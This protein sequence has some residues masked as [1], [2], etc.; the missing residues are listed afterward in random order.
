[1]ASNPSES[2]A[3]RAPRDREQWLAFY[4]GADEAGRGQ[5]PRG[6]GVHRVALSGKHL[7]GMV[8]SGLS[9][10]TAESLRRRTHM[11]VKHFGQ[12][13]P[14][15]TLESKRQSNQKLSA[16]QSDRVMRVAEVYAHAADV[17]GDSERAEKWMK[18]TNPRMP[19][20]RTPEDMLRTSY[21]ARYVDDVL[22]Q[23]EHGIPA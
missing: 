4:L 19:E 16:E 17:F 2:A 21:G 14:R 23:I 12:F 18:R 8:E 6:P 9:V 22:T 20:G 5:A 1:M 11:T 10:A 13:I 7:A 15:T 3:R